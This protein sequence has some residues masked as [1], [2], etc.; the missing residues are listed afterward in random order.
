MG[1]TRPK[2]RKAKPVVTANTS[3][4][5]EPPSISSLLQKAQSLIVQCDYD[6][7]KLFTQRV[8]E[9]EPK[10][11]EAREML[12]VVHLET[13]EIEAAKKVC[14]FFTRAVCVFDL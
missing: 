11:T 5:A 3:E 8:L 7:A 4:A 6:L 13:G 14:A 10:N 2:T 9:R 12:G 1:R